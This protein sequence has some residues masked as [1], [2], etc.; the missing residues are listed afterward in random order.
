M[1]LWGFPCNLLDIVVLPSNNSGEEAI[2]FKVKENRLEKMTNI[3]DTITT[4]FD[5]LDFIVETLDKTATL[6]L[7]KVVGNVVEVIIESG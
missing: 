7:D 3:K 2:A 5:D 4:P 6:P 1:V